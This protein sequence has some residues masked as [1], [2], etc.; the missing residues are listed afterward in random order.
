VSPNARAAPLG[1][2]P[3]GADGWRLV[4]GITSPETATQREDVAV[5]GRSAMATTGQV[6]VSA[7]M[8]AALAFQARRERRREGA[9]H[10]AAAMEDA[11]LPY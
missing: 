10:F 9:R 5:T 4:W 7:H 8:S 2:H 3:Q 1:G 6:L 11:P